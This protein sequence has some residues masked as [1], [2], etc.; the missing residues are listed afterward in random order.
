VPVIVKDGNDM[1]VFIDSGN[2]MKIAS[3]FQATNYG[4]E[5]LEVSDGHY[6]TRADI[7]T[8]VD[9]MSDVNNTGLDFMQKYNDMIDGEHYQQYKDILAASWHQ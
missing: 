6:I 2:Y 9:T 8:I 1:Y 4:I 5:R 7:Q 3:E